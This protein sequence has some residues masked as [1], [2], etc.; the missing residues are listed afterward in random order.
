MSDPVGDFACVLDASALLALLQDEP[1]A[2][3]VE[4]AL[5]AAVISTVNWSEVAQKSLDRGV[6]VCATTWAP[7]D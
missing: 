4:P 2:D 5:E 3:V 7:W 6:G 1:G